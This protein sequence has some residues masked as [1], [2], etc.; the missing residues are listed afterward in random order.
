MDINGVAKIGEEKKHLTSYHPRYKTA[1]VIE[2]Q[3][4]KYS[5]TYVDNPIT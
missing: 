2:C 3:V 1:V 4:D 5:F